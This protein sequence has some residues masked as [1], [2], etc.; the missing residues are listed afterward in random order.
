MRSGRDPLVIA[1]LVVLGLI[2]LGFV[3]QS[4]VVGRAWLLHRDQRIDDEIAWLE[5]MHPMMPW[6]RGLDA[7]IG[8]LYRERVRVPLDQGQLEPAVQ[9]F[10]AA[11][12]R[13]LRLGQPVDRDLMALGIEVY[14]RAADHVEKLGRLSSA[15]DWDDSL[16]VLAVRAD[17]P[18]HRYAATAAF[19]E[20][21]DLR[22]RDGQPCA[23]LARVTWAK[24][25]LG[26]VVPALPAGAESDLEQQCAGSR[27]TGG[28]R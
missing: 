26:G 18:H 7:Q 13:A 14:T 16:F 9:A 20:G 4:V 21:L 6:E 8:M 11:R 3:L 5:Q 2:G 25:G 17:E 19:L 28:R 15:A 24:M 23:A 27:R 1:L 10:R 22:V 12:T